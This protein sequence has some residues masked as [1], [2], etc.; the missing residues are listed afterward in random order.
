MTNLLL[1]EYYEKS[2][3]NKEDDK[4]EQNT[5]YWIVIGIINFIFLVVSPLL[6]YFI[7]K[8]QKKNRGD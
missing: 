8:K 7:V 1:K 3:D 2:A 6:R 4:M 5:K